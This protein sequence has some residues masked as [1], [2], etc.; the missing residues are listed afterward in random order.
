[1]YKVVLFLILNRNIRFVNPVNWTNDSSE[2]IESWEFADNEVFT[3]PNID[4]S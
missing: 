3:Y 1:M 2:S 4:L